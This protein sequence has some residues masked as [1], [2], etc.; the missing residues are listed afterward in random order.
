MARRNSDLVRHSIAAVTLAC[1][2]D[3][4]APAD[5][6]SVTG[7]GQI[8]PGPV[9]TPIWSVGADLIVGNT[10]A[11]SLT[12]DAGA[13]VDNSDA[14]IGNQTGSAGT[15]TVSGSD[16][17]G[18]ASTWTNAGMMRIGV[19]S[20]SNGALNV[21]GGGAVKGDSAI[22]G[23]ETGSVGVVTCLLYTSPS[24]RD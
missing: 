3:G 7:T 20:G 18:Q 24:P 14:Y 17:G 15:V 16:G 8:T 6:Q 11:G 12:I 1:A 2:V 21:L 4:I 23:D 13:T 5:A 10:A 22:I 9:Q 19:E